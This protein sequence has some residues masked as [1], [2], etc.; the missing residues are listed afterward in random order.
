[1]LLAFLPT[2]ARLVIA[3]TSEPEGYR[4]SIDIGSLDVRSLLFRLTALVSLS[5]AML[6]CA[7]VSES[8]GRAAAPAIADSVEMGVELG[9]FPGDVQFYDAVFFVPCPA[10]SGDAAFPSR[11]LVSLA[12]DNISQR[13]GDVRLKP[14]HEEWTVTFPPRTSPS[15]AAVS[16]GRLLTAF[17]RKPA[18]P[19]ILR[20]PFD[21]IQPREDSQPGVPVRV[22]RVIDA[23]AA[24][25]TAEFSGVY[26]TLDPEGNTTGRVAVTYRY[27]FGPEK[28][29]LPTDF[30]VVFP[31]SR[32]PPAR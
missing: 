22:L 32:T 23:D 16:A 6:S 27:E 15:G 12:W 21:I 28:G 9:G 30:A 3:K 26:W 29:W 7:G 1:M 25:T 17:R 10:P 5:A 13:L 14:A 20:S 11:S 24:T 4:M 18:R 8:I 19:D 2:C 31:L